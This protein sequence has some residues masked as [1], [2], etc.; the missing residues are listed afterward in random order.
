MSNIW[1][2][3]IDVTKNGIQETSGNGSEEYPLTW[4]G[5]QYLL[6]IRLGVNGP[7]GYLSAIGDDDIVKLRGYYH[8]PYD[9]IF[10]PQDQ[11]AYS[12]TGVTFEAWNIEEYGFWKMNSDIGSVELFPNY[13]HSWERTTS[14]TFKDFVIEDCELGTNENLYD[15]SK[16][17]LNFKNGI[18]IGDLTVR[19]ANIYTPYY[20]EGC[21]FYNG[22]YMA[23]DGYYG[24]QIE[25]IGLSAIF[26]DSVFKD[27]NFQLVQDTP[28]QYQL[29]GDYIFNYCTFDSTSAD[30]FSIEYDVI[31]FNNSNFNWL[32][33]TPFPDI[34]DISP[35]VKDNLSF[36]EFDLD[37]TLMERRHLWLENEF[38]DGV[39][40]KSRKGPGAFY[41][42]SD[43][44]VDLSSNDIGS[45]NIDSPITSAQFINYTNSYDSTLTNYPKTSGICDED[46]FYIKGEM[47]T[48]SFSIVGS[49]TCFS[50]TPTFYFNGWDEPARIKS[51]NDITL[52]NSDETKTPLFY[53]SNI[54]LYGYSFNTWGSVLGYTVF[55]N[56]ND[57]IL[58][59][60]STTS[61]NYNE[62]YG[63][64]I[65]VSNTVQIDNTEIQN[66]IKI[67]D[68]VFNSSIETY[69][70]DHVNV[71]Y[72]SANVTN[73]V[74]TAI[75]DTELKEEAHPLNIINSL[76]TSDN[77]YGWVEPTWPLYNDDISKF[78]YSNLNNGINI[79][80]SEEW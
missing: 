67:K 53:L 63:S 50:N 48:D 19:M 32:T 66:Y 56:V 12:A 22:T 2:A 44:Y 33:N 29:S 73:S 57:I 77:Q 64:T 51:T 34:L 17:N 46:S 61:T 70:P 68:C 9:V 41:F 14:A 72:V 71:Y 62:F 18:F 60:R 59:N 36:S 15:A 45:G 28:Y 24:T 75:D 74:L 65:L 30:I 5:L 1:Y 69:N 38:N 3:D 79:S 13:E 21:T 49:G 40:G 43:I 11:E 20:F 76:S 78:T 52:G 80:G 47:N 6:D 25:S 27:Y 4:D 39:Y 8:A 55:I 10:I 54:I 37:Y 58:H 42:N 23:A 26:D 7:G 16:L 31:T 35:T